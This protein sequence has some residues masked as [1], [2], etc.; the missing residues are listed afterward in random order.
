LGAAVGR[1]WMYGLMIGGEAGVEQVIKQTLADL[2]V[3]LGLSG[4]KNLEEIQGK[5]W[6]VISKVDL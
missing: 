1:P 4:Y 2:E 5:R 3:T 6:N